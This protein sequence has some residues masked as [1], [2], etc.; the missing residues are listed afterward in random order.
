MRMNRSLYIFTV[1]SPVIIWCQHTNPLAFYGEEGLIT[2]SQ[3]E[4]LAGIGRQPVEIRQ[5]RGCQTSGERAQVVL[6]VAEGWVSVTITE[7]TRDQRH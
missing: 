1:F 4:R 5:V 6:F 7:L 2:A 3:E